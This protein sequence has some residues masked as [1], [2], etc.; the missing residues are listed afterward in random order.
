MTRTDNRRVNRNAAQAPVRGRRFRVVAGIFYMMAS[1]G[2]AAFYGSM[3]AGSESMVSA[4]ALGCYT[5]SLLGW[6]TG[7]LMDGAAVNDYLS[8]DETRLVQCLEHPSVLY[9]DGSKPAWWHEVSARV[10]RGQRGSR[11]AQM[12][13]VSGALTFLM[14]NVAM[15]TRFEPGLDGDVFLI[16]ML[17]ASGLMEI[18]AV[19]LDRAVRLSGRAFKARQE[20]IDSLKKLVD[21]QCYGDSK[22]KAVSTDQRLTKRNLEL[23]E[24]IKELQ[25]AKM[26]Q[27]S[28]IL[29]LQAQNAKLK[30][31]AE[32]AKAIL[33]KDPGTGTAALPGTGT[34]AVK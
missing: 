28:M 15:N 19:A 20:R 2:V 34:A 17:S 23:Q 6:S 4:I 21:A 24:K 27:A 25:Q 14:T 26:G 22:P 16:L 10:L 1:L 7:A 33:H 31:E 9:H 18:A 13:M 8:Q 29:D 32:K 11:T 3:G 5:L 30:A 12:A